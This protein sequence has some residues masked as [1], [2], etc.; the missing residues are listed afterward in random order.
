[1]EIKRNYIKKLGRSSDFQDMGVHDYHQPFAGST[2]SSGSADTSGTNDDA[3]Q[4]TGTGNAPFAI[5]INGAAPSQSGSTVIP[6]SSFT[7]G[8]NSGDFTITRAG[9]DAGGSSPQTLGPRELSLNTGFSGTF[10][11]GDGFK[12]FIV[13]GVVVFSKNSEGRPN[14]IVGSGNGYNTK[15]YVRDAAGSTPKFIEGFSSLDSSNPIYMFRIGTVR[16]TKSG[17]LRRVYVTQS[18]VGGN[19]IGDD[20]PP[21]YKIQA[22]VDVAGLNVV[23]DLLINYKEQPAP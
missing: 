9:I 11:A 4:D 17:S 18:V 2:A 23:K 6:S 16:S 8:C 1:M 20:L 5:L 21:T 15:I 19:E 13:F 10:T 22:V 12:D 7:I 3:N 14:A